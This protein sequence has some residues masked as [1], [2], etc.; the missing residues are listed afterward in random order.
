[1]RHLP[2]AAALTLA[3]AACQPASPPP[4]AAAA[5]SAQP[6]Q[7][8]APAF[9]FE[10]ASITDLQAKM[11]SGALSSFTRSPRPISTASPRSTAP[12]PH[13]TR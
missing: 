12:A 9:A 11:A 4:S 3:L 13:S 5:A 6:A 2:L 1:M 7:T 10:E 8:T